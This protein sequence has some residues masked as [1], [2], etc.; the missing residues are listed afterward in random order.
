MVLESN[1]GAAI[2]L[3]KMEL[4]KNKEIKKIKGGLGAKR[5]GGRGDG[6]VMRADKGDR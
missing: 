3:A 4:R 5:R 6:G 2:I 1:V